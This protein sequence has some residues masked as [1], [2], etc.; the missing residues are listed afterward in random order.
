[1]TAYWLAAG[2][3]DEVEARCGLRRLPR[4]YPS[5]EEALEACR[6]WN[7]WY[8]SQH[9]DSSGHFDIEPYQRDGGEV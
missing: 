2:D 7:R 8:W 6:R 9:P 4:L 1:M 3:G 5:Y